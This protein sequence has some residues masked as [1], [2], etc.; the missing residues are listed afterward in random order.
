M[1]NTLIRLIS[2]LTLLSQPV[3]LFVTYIVLLFSSRQAAACRRGKRRLSGESESESEFIA[4][5]EPPDWVS[6]RAAAP[7]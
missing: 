1:T 2:S 7:F 6:L 3:L 5:G 4:D